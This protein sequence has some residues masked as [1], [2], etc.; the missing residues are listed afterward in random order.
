M[1]TIFCL[2]ALAFVVWRGFLGYPP[3]NSNYQYLS[4]AEAAFLDAANE[5]I[6]PAGGAIEASYIDAQVTQYTNDYLGWHTRRNRLL[7]HALFYLLEHA[8]LLFVPSLQRMSS[9]PLAAREKYMKSWESSDIYL[10]RLVFTSLRSILTMA[11]C[12][13]PTVEKQMG[14]FRPEACV[15]NKVEA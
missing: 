13:H 11:Y 2:A 8:T 15:K 7:M 1:C 6:F 14:I 9:L 12:A 4:A 5:V 3:K 10:K